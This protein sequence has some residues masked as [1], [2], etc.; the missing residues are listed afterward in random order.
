MLV[1]SRKPGESIHIG[2]NIVITIC[3]NAGG[4]VR[5]G[6][7]CPRDIPIRRSELAVLDLLE[8]TRGAPATKLPDM[9]L[10]YP[11]AHSIAADI[12]S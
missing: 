9:D 5:I 12:L 1:L 8:A 2:S 10:G 11:S 6:I 7:S 3:E 4:R